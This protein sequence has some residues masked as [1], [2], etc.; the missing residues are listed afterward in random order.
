[1]E[2]ATKLRSQAARMAIY[3]DGDLHARAL[4]ILSPAE[5]TEKA[6][7]PP[8]Y[9]CV[10]VLC[11]I[12]IAPHFCNQHKFDTLRMVTAMVPQGMVLCHGRTSTSGRH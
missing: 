7:V 2:I 10:C 9:L 6:C 12:S 11:L 1:M 5:L 4:A 3:D 8:S